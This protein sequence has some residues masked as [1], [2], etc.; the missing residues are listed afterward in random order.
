MINMVEDN[1]K[2]LPCLNV[3]EKKKNIKSERERIN[4][5]WEI[6]SEPN[7]M[8]NTIMWGN[9]VKEKTASGKKKQKTHAYT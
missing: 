2:R 5:P 3:K 7:I 8:K 9:H 6:L 4:E 1:M